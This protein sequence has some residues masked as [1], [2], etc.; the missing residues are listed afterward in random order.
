MARARKDGDDSYESASSYFMAECSCPKSV[1]GYYKWACSIRHC[2]ECKDSKPPS[3]KCQSSNDL[4]N[5]DQFVQVQKEYL[6]LNKKSNE[7]EKKSTKLTELD[8]TQMTYK[9]LYKKLN[10]MRKSYTTHKYHVYNDLYH[11]PII[12]TISEYGK[13]T[14]SDYSENMT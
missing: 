3:L 8:T 9:D 4:V 12:S 1:N 7:I 11:W 2:K 6:K 5:V 10:S 13:I 14:H